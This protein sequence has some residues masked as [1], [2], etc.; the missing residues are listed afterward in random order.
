VKKI[1]DDLQVLIDSGKTGVSFNPGVDPEVIG[2]V[3][4]ALDIRFPASYKAF[5]ERFDGGFFYGA[6]LKKLMDKGDTETVKWNAFVLLSLEEL[7]GDYLDRMMMGWKVYEPWYPYPYIPFAKTADNERL[8]FVNLRDPEAESPV[9]DAFHEEPANS[10][11]LV[12]P[13]FREFLRQY[14]QEDGNPET[15]GDEAPQTAESLAWNPSDTEWDQLAAP[16][17]AEKRSEARRQLFP[18]EILAMLP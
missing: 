1:L 6:S 18:E 9:F 15:I 8:V 3:E 13:S 14:V 2:W 12:A 4:T 10:W 11:G 16:E 17:T 5:L 7:V